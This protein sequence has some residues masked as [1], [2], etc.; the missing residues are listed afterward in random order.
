M[1]K[2]NWLKILCVSAILFGAMVTAVAQPDPP[3]P[4]QFVENRPPN[5]VQALGLTQDQFRQLRQMNA[6]LQPQLKESERAMRQARQALDEAIYND[7]ADDSLIRERLQ[8][9]QNAQAEVAKNRT[10]MEVSIRR[11]LTREQMFKFRQLRQRAMQKQ[12][13]K[14]LGNPDARPNQPKRQ[15][16]RRLGRPIN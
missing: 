2:F 4:T 1:K 3:P 8:N 15:L 13:N 16:Q 11:I 12:K 7:E 5:L 6:T 14:P 9:F 10:M